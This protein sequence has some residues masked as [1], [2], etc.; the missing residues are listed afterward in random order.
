MRAHHLLLS[1]LGTRGTGECGFDSRWAYSGRPPVQR[2]PVERVERVAEPAVLLARRAVGRQK[3]HEVRALP[4]CHHALDAA[5]HACGL[6][7]DRR[8]AAQRERA[9]HFE[10]GGRPMRGEHAQCAREGRTARHAHAH[11]LEPSPAEQRTETCATAAVA[12]AAAAHYVHVDHAVRVAVH[13]QARVVVEQHLAVLERD[14]SRA[15]NTG[16]CHRRHSDHHRVERIDPRA[17]GRPPHR[18]RA[19]R[20]KRARRR[21]RQ[22]ADR[23]RHVLCQRVSGHLQQDANS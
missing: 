12:A 5:E 14:V 11:K 9:A 18:A 17:I 7:L 4:A 15:T 22:R 21:H 3:G 6:L 19:D 23:W 10:V 8:V 16:A 20:V 13:A 1:Q 2:G